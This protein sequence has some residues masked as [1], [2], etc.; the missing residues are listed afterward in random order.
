MPF[1][2]W[3]WVFRL[4]YNSIVGIC[5]PYHEELTNKL[6]LVLHVISTTAAIRFPKGKTEKTTT[7]MTKNISKKLL[8]TQAEC[9]RKKQAYRPHTTSHSFLRG[10]FKKFCNSAIKKNGNVTNSTLFLNTITT[11]F[12]A[13]RHFFWQTVNSTKIETFCLPSSHSL[14]ASLSALSTRPR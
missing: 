10:T 5:A 6:D 3:I 11:Q 8:L 12:N 4:C 2:V 14:V 9:T 1:K 7:R 13:L